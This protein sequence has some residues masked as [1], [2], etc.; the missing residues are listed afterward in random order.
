MA[1]RWARGLVGE[2]V[3]DK[4][5]HG[6]WHTTT[7]IAGLRY[8]KIDAP[9]VFDGPMDAECFR[10]YVRQVLVPC[11]RSGD[12]V[13][14]DNLSCHKVSGIAEM[15]LSAD[16]QLRYLPP[17]SPDMNPIEQVWSKIKSMLRSA[18]R[19][20]ITELWDAFASLLPCFSPTECA[21]YFRNSGYTLCYN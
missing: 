8:D 11:L 15:I 7:F 5:P 6:H 4:V 16:A 9:A 18:A 13:I 14:M 20:S 3:I 19:R 17:Y 21:N 12:I 1:R 2:R 10:A